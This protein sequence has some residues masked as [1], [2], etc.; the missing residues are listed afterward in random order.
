MP[1]MSEAKK[2]PSPSTKKEK[3]RL[4]AGIQ[5]SEKRTV[6]PASTAGAWPRSAARLNAPVAPAQTLRPALMART[7]TKAPSIGIRTTSGR[8]MPLR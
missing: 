6:S 3:E 1:R 5:G 7:G 2:R 8:V 4:I